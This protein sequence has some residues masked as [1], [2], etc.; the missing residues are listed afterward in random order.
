MLGPG[1]FSRLVIGYSM[2]SPSIKDS[3]VMPGGADG[4][5]HRVTITAGMARQPDVERR[6]KR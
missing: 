3:N 6:E 4:C 5:L 2:S 1:L